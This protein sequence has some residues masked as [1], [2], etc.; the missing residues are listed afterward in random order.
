M[1]FIHL[2]KAAD[3]QALSQ[4]LGSGNSSAL[5]Q[6]KKLNPHLNLA[7]LELGSML[8]LPEGSELGTGKAAGGDSLAAFQAQAQ[9]GLA[10]LSQR[11]RLQAETLKTEKQDLS[12]ALKSAG[13]KRLQEG[14]PALK[15]QLESAAVQ[16]AADQ[17]SAEATAKQL[18]AMDK[19]LSTELG[20]MGK[21]L[22]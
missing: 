8:L 21:F 14:D 15:K 16:A 12:S 18:E 3:L 9:A 7:K 17:K 13:L 2:N 1:R 19:L 20:R 10:A 11:A 22:G 5:A 4:Q 6:I